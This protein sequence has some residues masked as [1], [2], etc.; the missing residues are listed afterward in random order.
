MI[1]A[2]LQIFHMHRILGVRAIFR[3]DG[4]IP[5]TVDLL[6]RGQ[7][8]PHFAFIDPN[9]FT[10]M[11]LLTLREA[12]VK[13][14]GQKRSTMFTVKD[15]EQAKGGITISQSLLPRSQNWNPTVFSPAGNLSYRRVRTES[16][17]KEPGN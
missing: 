17:G 16:R 8:I 12:G 11:N 3:L 10:N 7:V 14:G 6:T 1:L 13:T 9:K 2:V 5:P 15:E 4:E